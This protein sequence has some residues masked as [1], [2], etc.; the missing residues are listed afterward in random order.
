METRTGDIHGYERDRHGEPVAAFVFSGWD[1]RGCAQ[2]RLEPLTDD[3][4]V[5]TAMF[6][7]D[8]EQFTTDQSRCVPGQVGRERK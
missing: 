1:D 8:G 7:W 3:M 6:V 5:V 4:A 2:Y